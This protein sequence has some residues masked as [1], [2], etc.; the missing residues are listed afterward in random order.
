[1]RRIFRNV[2]F[3]I[4][5]VILIASFAAVL[6]WLNVEY[7]QIGLIVLILIILFYAVYRIQKN[8]PD[9]RINRFV[10]KF[11]DRVKEI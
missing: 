7:P 1:M 11:F 5:L 10:K 2:L 9:S 8:R 3:S 6:V 4:I